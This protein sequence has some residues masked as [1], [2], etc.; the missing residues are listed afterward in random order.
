MKK[1]IPYVFIFSFL[2]VSFSSAQVKDRFSYLNSTEVGKF[3]KPLAT[4]VGTALNSGG[5]TTAAIPSLF[6]FSIGLR[7]MVIIVPDDQKTF[8]P[9]LPAGYTA[10]KKTATIYG[11]KDGG[12]IYSGPNGYIT[13]PGGIGESVIPMIFPQATLSLLGTEAM[14]RYVPKINIGETNID[15]FGFGI[16]HNVS[17]YFILLPVDIAVQFLYNSLSVKDLADIKNTAFNVEVSKTFGIVTAY[18]GLQFEHTKL[19]LNY[20][21]KGDSQS[22]DPALREDYNITA[23]V[24][25]DNKVR[26]TIGGV[27]KLS[28]LSINVD[29]SVGSQS[30]LVSGLTFGI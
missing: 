30:T 2:L 5:F 19:D 29:Y 12:A 4:S 26:M 13:Y 18:G 23:N 10:D 20:K 27:L 7:G 17:Q 6:G 22:G 15:F 9:T 21:I 28:F 11:P 25:G 14:I 24:N 3:A 16:K 8:T 1:M